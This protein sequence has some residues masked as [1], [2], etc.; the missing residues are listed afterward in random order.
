VFTIALGSDTVFATIHSTFGYIMAGLSRS[1]SHFIHM[2]CPTAPMEPCF[3]KPPTMV[4]CCNQAVPFAPNKTLSEITHCHDMDR[5]IYLTPT[6]I[7][8]D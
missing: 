5:G 4:Q 6:E 2:N 3:Q 1:P 8:L 7:S